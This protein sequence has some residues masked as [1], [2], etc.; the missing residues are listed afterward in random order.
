[1]GSTPA[2]RISSEMAFCYV[3]VAPEPLKIEIVNTEAISP[4]TKVASVRRDDGRKISGLVVESVPSHQSWMAYAVRPSSA[5][6]AWWT[7]VRRAD[8]GTL[9]IVRRPRA[10]ARDALRFETV[11]TTLEM[12]NHSKGRQNI[13]YGDYHV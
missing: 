11:R 13:L 10:D 9:A 6:L 8:I 2:G 4:S 1:M 7:A 5:S 12:A 3:K